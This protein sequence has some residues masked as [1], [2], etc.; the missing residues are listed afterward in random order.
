MKRRA[1]SQPPDGPGLATERD[2]GKGRRMMLRPLPLALLI[3]ALAAC[4]SQETRD[5]IAAAENGSV[6]LETGQSTVP[7]NAD[8]GPDNS[9]AGQPQ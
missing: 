8:A 2:H 1:A 3:A 4:H 7:A 9:A 5:R 6:N